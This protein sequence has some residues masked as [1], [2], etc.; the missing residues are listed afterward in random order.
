MN[1]KRILSLIIAM[2]LILATLPVGIVN[3]QEPV[4]LIHTTNGSIRDGV[5]ISNF[6]GHFTSGFVLDRGF[7]NSTSDSWCSAWS[8]GGAAYI[9]VN[10]PVSQQITE[11]KIAGATELTPKG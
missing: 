9:Q 11:I 4:D 7:N 1:R 10:F 3:A 5:Y 2:V 8:P 6:G